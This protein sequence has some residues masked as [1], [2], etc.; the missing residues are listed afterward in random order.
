[1][2]NLNRIQIKNPLVLAPMAG[3]VDSPYRRICL[4]HGAALVF[5]ELIS[6]EGIRRANRKTLDLLR[7]HQEERP[8][9]IQIFG[10]DPDVMAEAA[11]KLED[12]GPDLIDINM[13][14]CAPKVCHSG[15][16]AGLLRDLPLLGAIA[17]QVASAVSLPVSA[18]IRIG[19]DEGS[20]NYREVVRT[21]EDSGISFLSVHGR[22]RSQ[23]YTG[24]ADW[25]AIGEICSLTALPV[26]GNG[27]I[28]SHE[29]A[30]ER[31]QGTG[32]RA[33]MIGRASLGNPWIFSG[34]RPNL[35][36][37]IAQAT[38]HLDMM[39]DYYGEY[40]IILMR[41]HLVKYIHGIRNAAS[42]RASLLSAVTRAEV[43][44]KLGELRTGA[45]PPAVT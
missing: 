44:D 19:W 4:R 29:E 16:G 26:I 43:L 13:G 24:R 45:S 6:A 11:R 35:T 41:K 25:D 22:T 2:I 21:L 10:K 17:R 20:R 9:G 36:E 15:S 32:C 14:C 28:S 12:L 38:E 8:L 30:L 39:I 1:M 18:K 27:D 3:F 42:I 33:V 23:H 37:T 5:T 7:F 40:G 31:L 34:Y